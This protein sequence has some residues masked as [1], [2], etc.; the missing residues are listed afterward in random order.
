M[1]LKCA[2]EKLLGLHSP[3]ELFWVNLLNAL[4]KI[5]FLCVNEWALGAGKDLR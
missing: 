5:H 1:V 4:V 3:A 2:A